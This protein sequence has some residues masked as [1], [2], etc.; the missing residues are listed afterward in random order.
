VELPTD[1]Y[2]GDR[3]VERQADRVLTVNGLDGNPGWI[4]GEEFHLVVV[5][6]VEHPPNTVEIIG[7]DSRRD[8]MIVVKRDHRRMEESEGLR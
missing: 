2:H 4:T 6:E 7:S 1:I 5:H 8:A 3:L